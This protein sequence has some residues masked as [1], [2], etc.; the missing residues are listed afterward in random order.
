MLVQE[1]N[2]ATDL[3][4]AEQDFIGKVSEILYQTTVCAV[5][6]VST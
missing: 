2:T 1:R 5:P 3:N 4:Q 6:Q